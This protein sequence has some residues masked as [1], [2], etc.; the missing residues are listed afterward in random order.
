MGHPNLV[1][2]TELSQRRNSS[3]RVALPTRQQV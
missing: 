3:T 2:T 1:L